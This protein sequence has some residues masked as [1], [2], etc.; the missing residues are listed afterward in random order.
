MS[1]CYICDKRLES[2][3]L[4]LDSVGRP[5][6]CTTCHNVTLDTLMSYDIDNDDAVEGAMERDDT[7]AALRDLE[8]AHERIAELREGNARLQEL[9]NTDG[10]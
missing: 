5:L 2:S 7:S 3:E 8:A 9:A 1:R 4:H 10:E 6:P